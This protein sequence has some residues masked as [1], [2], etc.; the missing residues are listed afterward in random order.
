[1]IDLR[2]MNI[3][4]LAHM[5]GFSVGVA[6]AP[7]LQRKTRLGMRRISLVFENSSYICRVNSFTPS[8]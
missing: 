2:N 7:V 4:T 5:N 8:Q 1:M 3:T 6:L